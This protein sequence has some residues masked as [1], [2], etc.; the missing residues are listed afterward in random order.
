MTNTS[1]LAS[2]VLIVVAA[3]AVKFWKHTSHRDIVPEDKNQR[4]F[5]QWF[6]KNN[7]WLD[8]HLGL[9]TGYTG[10]YDGYGNAL[11]VHGDQVEKYN[12]ILVVPQRIQISKESAITEFR[13]LL[14]A[15]ELETEIQMIYDEANQ[16][17]VIALALVIESCLG[18][19]SFF[20]P[21][22]NVLPK[23]ALTLLFTFDD[24]EL[25]FM[26]DEALAE[27]ARE[28][29]A[30]LRRVWSELLEPSARVLVKR[31]MEEQGLSI[32]DTAAASTASHC[33][34]QATFDRFYA[35]S[36]SRS[37]ILD[38]TKY[39]VPMAD[40]INHHARKVDNSKPDENFESFHSMEVVHGSTSIVVHADRR[41]PAGE[42]SQLLEEYGKLD[43]SLYLVSFGFV[44]I[45][46][47]Y[48]CALL[49]AK[50]FPKLNDPVLSE[51]LQLVD[52]SWE[53]G[54]SAC[55]HRDGSLLEH[56]PYLA[57]YALDQ[58]NGG[59]QVK[60][61]RQICMDSYT[62][63]Q[64]DQETIQ[65]SCAHQGLAALLDASTKSK[66]FESAARTTLEMAPTTVEQ[67]LAVLAGLE[68]DSSESGLDNKR[69][70][71]AVWFRIEE[72]RLI[73]EIAG[74]LS[75]QRIDL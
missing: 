28:T 47:P 61:H 74:S 57:L 26:Q 6:H 34:T 65:R 48:H 37:M 35:I 23:E 44:P 27:L 46:N 19:H 9:T 24:T 43:N 66:L 62:S 38:G 63:G 53:T 41:T 36:S 30:R 31:A 59:N 42:A 33:L 12:Q 52:P 45:D 69:K 5:L 20:E 25:E 2:A 50:Y 64:F 75:D 71:L 17:E 39:L 22:L 21:Y 49:R 16:D 29:S 40:M 8:A 14:I 72:K 18:E 68:A 58:S 7:G 70:V 32:N 55:V 51:I 10:Y 60:V 15:E 3:F 56:V 13:R 67:D 54:G 1:S 4:R 11:T 73:R